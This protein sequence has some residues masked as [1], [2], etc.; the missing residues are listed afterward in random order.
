MKT[1]K[2]KVMGDELLC[3]E[4]FS[5]YFTE[6]ST[7]KVDKNCNIWYETKL[8]SIGLTYALLTFCKAYQSDNIRHL[9]DLT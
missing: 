2:F 1:K 4:T 3:S 5:V 7:L 6:I 9:I 8:I